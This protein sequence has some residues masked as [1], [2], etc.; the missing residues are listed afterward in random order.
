MIK[1]DVNDTL[2]DE[3]LVSIDN[4][5]RD[6]ENFEE[7]ITMLYKKYLGFDSGFLMTMSLYDLEKFFIH[8]RIKDYSKL[9]VLGILFIEQWI[10]GQNKDVTGFN[11]L[12]KGF[13]ILSDVYLNGRDTKVHYYK[14]YLLKASGVLD[15]YEISLEVKKI[16]VKVYLKELFIT[17]VDDLVFDILN[18]DVSYGKEAKDIYKQILML[19][20]EKLEISGLTKIEIQ[21]SIDEITTKY[22]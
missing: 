3:L 15:E 12:I 2:A 13:K 8:N 9:C 7:N 19:P 17:K 18:E 4:L 20:N 14:D 11:K 1:N 21:E 5:F 22:L 16:M 10:E 6:K